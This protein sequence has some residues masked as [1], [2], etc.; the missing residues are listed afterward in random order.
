MTTERTY[1]THLDSPLGRL[2]LVASDVGLRAVLWPAENPKLALLSPGAIE[3][4][5]HPILD[6]AGKQLAAYFSHKRRE[7]DLPFDLQGTQF[8]KMAWLALASIPYGT[9]VSYATQ[10][11]RIGRPAAVRAVGAANGRNPVPIIL[12]CHR[13]VGANGS[14]VGYAAGL[15]IK[16]WLLEHER[17]DRQPRLPETGT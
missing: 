17:G 1:R 10:A 3:V 5:S 13:V 9:T 8:Q 14:L 7:F 16:K 2:T 6:A 11:S 4:R 15:D 12:P